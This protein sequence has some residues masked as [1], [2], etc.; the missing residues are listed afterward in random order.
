MKKRIVS[1]LLALC[2]VLS[3]FV[4]A[5]CGRSADTTRTTAQNEATD[6]VASASETEATTAEPTTDKWVDLAPMVTMITPKD[7]SLKI[8][9]DISRNGV[10]TSKNDVYVKG[11][12]SVED[13]ITPEIEVMVYERN[14]AA[15]E[16]LGLTIEYETWTQYYGQQVDK[17]DVLVKGNADGAP[18]LFICLLYD[19]NLELLN[20]AFKD[21]W[22]IPGSFFDFTTDGWLKTWMENMSLTGDRAYVLGGDY[23]LELLRSVSV[24]PFNMD[25]MDENSAKLAPIILNE[26]ETLGVG[27]E[28]TTYFFDLVEEGK[29]TYDV[30]GKLCEAIWVDKDGNEQD[31]IYDVLGIL[32]DEYGGKSA[33]GFI[34]SDNAPLTEAY[35]IEDESSEYYGK[36]W[37]KYADNSEDAGLNEIFDA[38]SKVFVGKGSLSTS[39]THSSN[40]PEAPGKAY[41]L[42]KFAQD[43]L[44]FLGVDLL[45]DLEDDRIQAMT[46]LYSVIP[47]A[48]VSV[49]RSYNSIIDNTGDAGAINVNANPRKARVLSAYIQYCTEHS[50]H[51]RK[52][53]LEIVTKY[54]TTT[55]NQGTD[56]MLEM[57]YEGIL[58]GRD[59]AVDDL[60][61]ASGRGSRWHDIMKH[62]HHEAGSDFITTQYASVITTRQTMLNKNLETWYTL[63]K[64]ESAAAN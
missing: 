35:V 37:I 17:I 18:D 61:G 1:L 5:S 19:L 41:H 2:F 14:R 29:W 63:P 48:K 31:S 32:A 8:A 23:F 11:P 10:K 44:L 30:L 21:V 9:C 42:T 50:A 40:T 28:L 20:G 47:C 43:E 49:D 59:K 13:G 45:G 12:D 55:Y 36:Q 22:S 24:M 53:F 3:A 51:I 39:A 7:R 26:G 15:K 34:Y 57:I 27:E 52:E 4:L 46:S 62:E 60:F 58:Y 25:L 56:R 38:V 54:K 33:V 6:P 64:V 16:L